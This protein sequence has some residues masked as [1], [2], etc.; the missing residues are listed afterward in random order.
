MDSV[1]FGRALGQGARE[2]AKA[3]A[4]AADAAAAPAPA[5]KPNVQKA[6]APRVVART[7][8][9]AKGVREGGRRFGEA[10]WGPFVKVSGI[11]WLE[12]MGVFF[13]I[14]TVFAGTSAWRMRPGLH[15]FAES[16]RGFYVAAG[17]AV[18]FGYFCVSNFVKAS[19]RGRR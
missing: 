19:R 5:A 14:F 7:V 18:V 13:A 15:G 8:R 16:P 3:L 2:A 4:S 10:M 12:V 9:T 1:R 6:A 11:V 17:M